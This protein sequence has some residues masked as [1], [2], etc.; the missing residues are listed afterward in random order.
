MP[1]RNHL[2]YG[3]KEWMVFVECGRGPISSADSLLVDEIGH[4]RSEHVFSSR[5]ILS[6]ARKS[7]F[8]A[9]VNRR[10]APGKEEQRVSKDISRQKFLA[11]RFGKII[12]Q[13]VTDPSN[14]MVPEK[15]HQTIGIYSRAG[16]SESPVTLIGECV[17][18]QQASNGERPCG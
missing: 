18:S 17:R 5:G 8:I 2:S 1:D 3:A 10:D 16:S 12:G 7:L 15:S 11:W 6:L 4:F 13:E 14:V 9:V